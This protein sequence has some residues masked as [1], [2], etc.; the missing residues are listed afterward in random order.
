[1]ANPQDP[2]NPQQPPLPSGGTQLPL[3]DRKNITPINIEDEMR[4]S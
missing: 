1:M 3:G 2:D 4:R